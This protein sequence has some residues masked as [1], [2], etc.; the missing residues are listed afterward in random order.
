MLRPFHSGT[1]LSW[2]VVGPD[3]SPPPDAA[4]ASLTACSVGMVVSAPGV[5]TVV[6]MV[7]PSFRVSLSLPSH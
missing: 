7:R 5:P 6:T 4:M 1:Q 2:L 3:T